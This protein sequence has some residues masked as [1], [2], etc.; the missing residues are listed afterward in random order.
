MRHIREHL[1]AFRPKDLR[2]PPA[3]AP[4]PVPAKDPDRA[5]RTSG[6]LIQWDPIIKGYG[7]IKC[8][9]GS[10]IFL[11]IRAVRASGLTN[12]SVGDR[13]EFSLE[14]DADAKTSAVDIE[15]V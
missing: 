1:D 13:L 4:A 10:D 11:G 14:K 7:W 5:E 9:Q 8:D 15:R 2:C 12:L 6:K 3:P